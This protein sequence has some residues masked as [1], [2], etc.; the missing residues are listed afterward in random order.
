MLYNNKYRIESIRLK[1]WNY[2][3]EGI[4]FITICT[5]YMDPVFG[6]V[7][8]GKMVLSKIGNIVDKYWRDIPNHFPLVQLD[9]YIVMPNHI[10]GIIIILPVEM[11]NIDVSHGKMKTLF[12]FQSNI[13]INQFM[14]NISPKKGSI[15]VIIRSYK[16]ICTKTV[17]Q[18]FT[19]GINLWQPRFWDHII[20]SE[21]DL[22]RIRKY[23]KNNPGKWEKR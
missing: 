4:Y 8:D 14:S 18:K 15:S 5:K 3:S 7:D 12:D 2:K 11:L 1:K 9:E 21:I 19:S 13:I 6:Y 20:R 17:N 16:S 22:N 23:I 10:H